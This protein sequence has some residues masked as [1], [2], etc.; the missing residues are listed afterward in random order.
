MENLKEGV[1]RLREVNPV[2]VVEGV[3]EVEETTDQFNYF[4]PFNKPQAT[5]TPQPSAGKFNLPTP[6][7]TSLNPLNHFNLFNHP[8]PFPPK[9]S[10]CMLKH[11]GVAGC[12]KL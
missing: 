5:S 2:E 3:E 4:N 6:P 7:S 8:N 12:A 11:F 10:S 1:E 9:Y